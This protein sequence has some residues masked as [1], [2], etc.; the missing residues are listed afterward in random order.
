MNRPI[1]R[2]YGLVAVLFALLVAFTSR[3]TV[4]EASS[5][6]ENPLN[7]RSL[8]RQER[9]E[10][11]EITAAD[12]TVLARSVR[13]AASSPQGEGV[14]QRYYPTGELFAAPI[15]YDFLAPDL[16]N[17]GLERYRN[18]ELSGE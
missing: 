13:G 18:K 14:Y 5:L 8:L 7:K 3:W 9:I 17:T 15:G 2:L 6:R 4:F 10:R 12:G 11:G 16:G 1:I